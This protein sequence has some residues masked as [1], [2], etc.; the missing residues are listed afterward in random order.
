MKLY[1]LK[2][3]VAVGI[4]EHT[5]YNEDNIEEIDWLHFV[6]FGWLGDD[7]LESRSYYIVT[8]DLKKAI[9]ESDLT[10][11][12]FK[13][14]EISLSYE[15]LEFEVHHPN[16]VLP[17]FKR[18]ISKGVVNIEGD[19]IEI[20]ESRGVDMLN[21]KNSHKKYT[22][23]LYDD[24]TGDDFCGIYYGKDGKRMLTSRLVVSEK[25]FNIMNKFNLT[26]CEKLRVEPK[27]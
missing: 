11:Y 7:I 19:H 14:V 26:Y 3:E 20:S 6:F 8:E 1:I 15:F 27:K 22:G 25:A 2:P 18:L 12:E 10:G 9:E 24:W 5:T 16:R 13:D 21:R 23:L 4:G 17:K